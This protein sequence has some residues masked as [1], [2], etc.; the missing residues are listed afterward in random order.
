MTLV[1][2][3][4]LQSNDIVFV[5]YRKDGVPP[6]GPQSYSVPIWEDEW[7]R[8]DG[9]TVNREHLLMALADVSAI[10]IKGTYTTFTEE[11]AISDVSLDTSVPRNTGNARAFEVEECRCPPGHTGLSCEDCAPGYKRSEEGLYLGFCEPCECNG[12]SEE[13]DADSGHCLVRSAD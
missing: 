3:V 9:N 1:S 5:H 8:L 11:A 4:R 6:A 7:Q 10:F 2:T 13:C 12:H